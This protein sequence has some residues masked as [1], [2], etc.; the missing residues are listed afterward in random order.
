M[1]KARGP[2]LVVGAVILLSLL[3]VAVPGCIGSSRGA[4]DDYQKGY[5]DGVKAERAKWSDQK[6]QLARTM[7]EEQENSQEN[8]ERLLKGE[9]DG[10]TVGEVKVDGDRAQVRITAN[11]KDGTAIGGTV[12][13]VRIEN[14]WYMQKVTSDKGSTPS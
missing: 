7:I 11:F 12:D 8:L 5:D 4:E 13:L 3:L 10:V 1:R 14:K 2:F 9:V 6:L